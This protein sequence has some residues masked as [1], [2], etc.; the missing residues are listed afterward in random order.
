[1]DSDDKL[2]NLE[3]RLRGTETALATLNSTI[4][5]TT[6]NLERNM[7][8]TQ[9]ELGD[10]MA[11]LK[12]DMHENRQATHDLNESLQNLYVSH[13][14]SQNTVKFNEK[15]VWGIVGIIVTA[16]LYFIQGFIKVGGA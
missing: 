4:N 10:R 9:S 7:A 5:L 11:D 3:E 12:E 6:T 15:L 1:M 8:R 2:N 14:G 16:G 13:S